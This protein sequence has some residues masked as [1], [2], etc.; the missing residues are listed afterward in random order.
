MSFKLTSLCCGLRLV[1]VYILIHTKKNLTWNPHMSCGVSL[2]DEPI[3]M[4][5]QRLCWL[6]LAFIADWKLGALF[7]LLRNRYLWKNGSYK[8]DWWQRLFAL[9]AISSW[10][11]F[12]PIPPKSRTPSTLLWKTTT[13]STKARL[14]LQLVGIY[15][16]INVSVNKLEFLASFFSWAQDLKELKFSLRSQPL[17]KWPNHFMGFVTQIVPSTPCLKITQTKK[18]KMCS[19]Q[20]VRIGQSF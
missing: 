4:L 3:I 13:L 5:G 7:Q 16:K 6:T 20:K 18:S 11:S 9:A 8:D 15:K 2:L 14:P 10:F 1:Q 12:H 17:K 19:K